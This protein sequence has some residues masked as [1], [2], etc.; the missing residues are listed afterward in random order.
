MKKAN[1]AISEIA[2]TF[3]TDRL[4]CSE[5]MIPS[6]GLAKSLTMKPISSSLPITIKRDEFIVLGFRGSD[7][8]GTELLYDILGRRVHIDDRTLQFLD[9][10][11]L[12]LEVMDIMHL[13]GDADSYPLLIAKEAEQDAAA[14]P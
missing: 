12:D 8:I 7:S 5:D 3:L 4:V 6:L 9:G 2:A 1:F 13:S 11:I 14:N 10:K